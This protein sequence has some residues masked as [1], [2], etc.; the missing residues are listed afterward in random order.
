MNLHFALQYRTEWGQHLEVEL[1]LCRQREVTSVARYPMETE[2]GVHWHTDVKILVKDIVSFEYQY[3]VSAG[4]LELRREWNLVPRHYPAADLDF[5]F[6]DFWRDIPR[7]NHLYSAAYVDCVSHFTPKKAQLVYFRQTLVFRVMAPFLKA[8]QRLAIIGSQPPLGAWDPHRYLSMQPA[9]INEWVISLSASGLYLPFEYKYVVVDE[10]TGELLQW[11]G[12]DNRLSPSGMMQDGDVVAISDQEV[13]LQPEHWKAAGVVVP[14]FSLRSEHSQGVGDFSDLRMMA[15]WAHSTGLGM[16]QLLPIYDTTQ[17]HTWTDCY[18]Y[19][20]ISI[21]AL[22]PMYVDLQALPPVNDAVYMQEYEKQRRALNALPKVDYE[23]VNKLKSDYLHRLFDQCWSSLQDDASYQ[24]FCQDNEWWLLRYA[25]FSMLRDRYRTSDF[26]TW[27]CYAEYQDEAVHHLAT[28]YRKELH[29]YIYVQYLLDRQLS[30]TAAYAREKGV[31]LKGDIPIGI[32]KCSVEAWAM[33]EYFHLDSQAG[34]PP[35]GFSKDGQNW[36]FPTYNW[37]RM[38]EDGYKWWKDRMRKMADYFGAYRIDH[39]LGFFRIWEIPQHCVTG[40]LGH[41]SPALPMSAD[42][43]RQYGFDF[44][45][46]LHTVPYITDDVLRDLFGERAQA[47]CA[48]CLKMEPGHRYTLKPE[49]DTQRKVEAAY[50]GRADKHSIMERD[51]LYKL[52]ANVLFVPDPQ[53][54]NRFH[55]RINAMD[56]SACKVLPAD[57]QKAFERLHEDFF[58]H[59][60][61]DFWRAEAMKKLPALVSSTNMLVCAEDL[62]MVPACVTPVMKELHMLSLEIQAMPKAFGLEFGRLE[63]NPYLSVS[64]VFTH[65][66]PTLRE[67]WEQDREK[68]QSYYNHVLLHDGP[69]PRA[70]PGWLAEEILARHMYSPSM[71]CLISLQDW[72]AMDDNLRYPNPA[73]ER[74]NVPSVAQHYWRYRMHLTIEQLMQADDFN[75]RVAALVRHGG[76]E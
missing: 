6:P 48:I 44:D 42:E 47:V 50:S 19:N 76:R 8:G 32:S 59:R 16:V 75:A 20:S 4:E 22:H 2:D 71:L 68:V 61:N 58:Y 27:P 52:I 57:Q 7:G 54:K 65:D 55:P 12:G 1:T 60:H 66:M 69:A 18:P 35:D 36:G 73:E 74:I 38:A 23:G 43:I 56:T 5:R 40:M 25:A 14:L 29:Y 62:G 28:K 26:R 33:P 39:V 24:R 11:E 3:V 53:D 46:A 34:A 63:D 51:G 67:W 64:T 9:G 70:L 17:T 31:V 30:E 10:A 41:F 45:P 72:L 49:Y 37:E 13:R 15:D 21:Y